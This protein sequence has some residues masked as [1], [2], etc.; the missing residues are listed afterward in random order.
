MFIHSC[1]SVLKGL[2]KADEQDEESYL[3]RI[4]LHNFITKQAD[5]TKGR[6]QEAEFADGSVG[7]AGERGEHVTFLRVIRGQG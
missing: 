1:V 6:Y 7:E 2:T 3:W 5:T 4:S